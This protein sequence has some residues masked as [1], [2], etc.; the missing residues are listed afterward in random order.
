MRR[1]VEYSEVISQVDEKG[2]RYPRFL[3]HSDVKNGMSAR[4]CSS[5]RQVN[6]LKI[7][8]HVGDERSS[9]LL[10]LPNVVA[11]RNYFANNP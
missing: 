9:G 10:S 8:K 4:V 3:T 2:N 11:K 6:N 1:V 7:P 5:R